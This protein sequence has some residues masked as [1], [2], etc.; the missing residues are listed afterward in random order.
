VERQEYGPDLDP[1]PMSGPAE[2]EGQVPDPPE[3][4]PTGQG[5]VRAEPERGLVIILD[6][7]GRERPYLVTR[8]E[9]LMVLALAEAWPG[10]V[11]GA[12]MRR[13]EPRIYNPAVI[14][15]RL[16]G[17]GLTGFRIESDAGR[18]MRLAID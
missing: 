3:T 17:K 14:L 4:S 10:W 8:A 18:R 2:P 5:R 12:E 1:G 13:R 15:A 6:A 7:A 16:R 11:S 9:A